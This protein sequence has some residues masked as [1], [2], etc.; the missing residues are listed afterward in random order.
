M[1]VAPRGPLTHETARS[2]PEFFEV[3]GITVLVPICSL[4]AAHS[5]IFA[6][7]IVGDRSTVLYMAPGSAQPIC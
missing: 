3:A 7:W 2:T 4:W 5:G 6:L 1:S